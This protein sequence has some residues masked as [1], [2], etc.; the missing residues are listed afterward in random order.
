VALK[1]PTV[2]ACRQTAA[3]KSHNG[4]ALPSRRYALSQR[5][6]RGMFIEGRLT[7]NHKLRRSDIGNMPLLTELGWLG[8]GE[9]IN[10]PVLTDFPRAYGKDLVQR[11]VAGK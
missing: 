4:G 11:F 2:A 9:T 3:D 10:M 8:N 1:N 5:Q 7:K 6:Q